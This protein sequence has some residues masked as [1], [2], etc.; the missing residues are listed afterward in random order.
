MPKKFHKEQFTFRI[1][2]LLTTLN[3]P[4]DCQSW[5][6][7]VAQ[8]LPQRAFLAPDRANK[9]SAS[10]REMNLNCLKKIFPTRL[11]AWHGKGWTGSPETASTLLWDIAETL[12][13]DQR[14]SNIW[15]SFRFE[16][17]RQTLSFDQNKVKT[18]NCC[19]LKETCPRWLKWI[20][21][22]TNPK[23]LLSGT[24]ASRKKGAQ[25]SEAW[26]NFDRQQ[27]IQNRPSALWE[28]WQFM[29]RD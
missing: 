3:Q 6:F 16:G 8:V 9:P 11:K 26:V 22:S 2:L 24:K 12:E 29:R 5:F 1:R 15:P 25:T 14:G 27:L 23:N 28:N 13:P 20:D 19:F 18:D 7:T 10:E 17:Q 21:S 4:F